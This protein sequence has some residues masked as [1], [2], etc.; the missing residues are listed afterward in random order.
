MKKHLIVTYMV[1]DP[2]V[3][4][5]ERVKNI[6]LEVPIEYFDD[7]FDLQTKIEAMIYDYERF[8]DFKGDIKII[9]IFA[10]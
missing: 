9:S 10:L 1:N 5:F 6:S 7:G 4:L 2:S 8:G 3:V